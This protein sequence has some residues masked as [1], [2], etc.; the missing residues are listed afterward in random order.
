MNKKPLDCWI[1]APLTISSFLEDRCSAR[2]WGPVVRCEGRTEKG[3]DAEI[4]RGLEGKYPLWVP[5]PALLATSFLQ[6]LIIFSRSKSFLIFWR[7]IYILE[8]ARRVLS[9]GA[10]QAD[11]YTCPQP[12]TTA[13]IKFPT[14]SLNRCLLWL[15]LV[16]NILLWA[17]HR[18]T[19]GH[20]L[21]GVEGLLACKTFSAKIGKVPGKSGGL[22]TLVPTILIKF[23]WF[24]TSL[25]GIR[26]IYSL[27]SGFSHTISVW[28]Y[29]Y[30]CM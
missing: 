6:P 27:V 29:P 14:P 7:W 3:V 13:Q 25:A 1:L 18:V 10:Q 11:F 23:A 21:P 16:C 5:S 26:C 28:V 12:V 22:V 17:R 8:S 9:F 19:D 4:C 2:V 30:Y 20:S 15:F 24:W